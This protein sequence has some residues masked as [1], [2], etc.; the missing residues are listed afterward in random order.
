MK[1]FK[2]RVTFQSIR[3]IPQ[4]EFWVS[5]TKI[6]EGS[7]E[8]GD[9]EDLAES[10]VEFIL[11]NESEFDEGFNDFEIVAKEDGEMENFH[12]SRWFNITK[13]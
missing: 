6:V 8:I 1:E 7:V 2:A 12:F 13:K 3:E 9:F 5:I 11:D 4:N 10:I